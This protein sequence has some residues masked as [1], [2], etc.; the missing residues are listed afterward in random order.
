MFIRRDTFRAKRFMLM[1]AILIV[2]LVNPYYLRNLIEYLGQQFYNAGQLE[3]SRQHGAKA[4][5]SAWLVGT[6]LRRHC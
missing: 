1:S 6:Y 3:K 4:P 5:D 2:A